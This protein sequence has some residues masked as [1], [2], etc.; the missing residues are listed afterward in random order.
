MT[1]LMTPCKLKAVRPL[2][3]PEKTDINNVIGSIK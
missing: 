3:R 2:T 1:F